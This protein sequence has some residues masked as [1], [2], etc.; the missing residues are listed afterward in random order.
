MAIRN[1]STKKSYIK[2]KKI[3]ICDYIEGVNENGYPIE[4][5]FPIPNGE[6]I[7]AYYRQASGNEFYAAAQVNAS[8]EA[9]FKINWRD[10]LNENMIIQ[11]KGKEYNI[12]R[13][14]DYEGYK[15][16]LTIYATTKGV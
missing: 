7:W 3:T 15:N 4:G 11:Y 16:D 6:N 13:I 14:D 5:L 10:D 9:I 1:Q 2:D 8:I 12:T